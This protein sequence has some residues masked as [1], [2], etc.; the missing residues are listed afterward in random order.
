MFTI[1]EVEYMSIIE[2][3][4]L[5]PAYIVY[6]YFSRLPKPDDIHYD[7]CKTHQFFIMFTFFNTEMC[8]DL[9]NYLRTTCGYAIT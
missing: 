8:F 2:L 1:I 9:C 7:K 6:F 3:N 5:N 4:I